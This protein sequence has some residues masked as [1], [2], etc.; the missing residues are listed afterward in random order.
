MSH[1]TSF[2]DRITPDSTLRG[3]EAAAMLAAVVTIF[4]TAAALPNGAT[5]HNPVT[6]WLIAD[7]SWWLVAAGRLGTVAAVFAVLAVL[8]RWR[9]RRYW[10]G[11][12]TLFAGGLW[13]NAT[14]D[15]AVWWA[16]QAGVADLSAGFAV[17]TAVL[18][19]ALVG[20]YELAAVAAGV[21]RGFDRKHVAHHVAVV[22]ITLVVVLGM[23]IAPFALFGMGG[24]ADHDGVAA[25]SSD[26]DVV[27]TAGSD[28]SVRALDISDG[29][30]DW[31]FS[32]SDSVEDVAIAP[33]GETVYS[34]GIDEKLRAIDASDGTEDWNFDGHDGWVVGVAVSPDGETVYTSSE[35]ESVR[36][37]GA[38]DGTEN[39]QS[40]VHSDGVKAVAV[41]PDGDVVYTA[42]SDGTVRGLDASDGTENWQFDDFDSA[43]GVAVS[44]DGE[45]VYA[46]DG[47][48]DDNVVALDASDGTENWRSGFDE[49][50]NAIVASPDG[51]S[52]YVARGDDSVTEFDASDGSEGWTFSDHTDSVESVTV[53]SDGGTVLSGSMDGT[54]WA[55]DASDG[56]QEWQ[57]DGHTASVNG[58]STIAESFG[59]GPQISGSVIESG[60]GD[61]VE[62]AVIEAGDAETTTDADGEYTLTVDEAFE[63]QTI[64]VTASSAIDERTQPTAPPTS[65]V[66]FVLQSG[67]IQVVDQHGNPVEGATVAVTGPTE[68][69]LSAEGVDP[70]EFRQEADALLDEFTSLPDTWDADFDI[71][72]DLV[73]NETR[74]DIGDEY[75]IAHNQDDWQEGGSGLTSSGIEVDEPRLQFDQGDEVLLTVWEMDDTLEDALLPGGNFINRMTGDHTTELFPGT[76]V[77]QS[78]EVE[79]IGPDG[80]V[81]HSWTADPMTFAEIERLAVS[82]IF[83]GGFSNPGLPMVPRP[84]EEDL[85]GVYFG[86]LAPGIYRVTPEGNDLG[87]YTFMYG[88]EDDIT[89]VWLEDVE[90]EAGNLL[91]RAEHIE[92]QLADPDWFHATNVS[93]SQGAVQFGNLPDDVPA[94]DI[95]A[96]KG[97]DAET[98]VNADAEGLWDITDPLEELNI[99]DIRKMDAA[100]LSVGTG[101]YGQERNV[102]SLPATVEG[103]STE[104]APWHEG[105]DE[106]I[107]DRI[108]NATSM[109][110]DDFT[111]YDEALATLLEKR[112]DL[113]E[114]LNERGPF[115]EFLC[116]FRAELCEDGEIRFSD[117]DDLERVSRDLDLLRAAA[118]EWDETRG[119]DAEAEIEDAI[120]DTLTY[121]ADLPDGVADLVNATGA[122]GLLEAGIQDIVDAEV[123]YEDGVTEEVGAEYITIDTEA[124]QLVI[125]E[126]DL[127]DVPVDDVR[128]TFAG[129][130]ESIEDDEIDH[131]DTVIQKTIEIEESFAEVTGDD[132]FGDGRL[133]P[134]YRVLACAD[135]NG[136]AGSACGGTET[137]R[138]PQEVTAREEGGDTFLD[139]EYNADEANIGVPDE[140]LLSGM[141][142]VDESDQEV[143]EA[144]DVEDRMAH[145]VSKTISL[146]GDIDSL[147]DIA[148]RVHYRDAA[149]ETI[150]NAHLELVDSSTVEV[151]SYPTGQRHP[152]Y[153]SVSGEI[154]ATVRDIETTLDDILNEVI[155][156]LGEIESL[157]AIDV[158]VDWDDGT[159]DTITDEY[160]DLEVVNGETEIH[161]SGLD[162]DDR[163]AEA[164]R[165]DIDETSLVENIASQHYLNAIIDFDDGITEFSTPDPDDVSVFFE[166]Q[167]G[168]TESIPPEYWS[169]DG[170]L[171]GVGSIVIEDYPID[172]D[173]AAGELEVIAA[174]GD[175]VY[176]VTERIE[177]PGYEGEPPV[178]RYVATSSLQPDVDQRVHLEVG[179]DDGEDIELVGAEA[180]GPTGQRLG[181]SPFAEDGDPQAMTEVDGSDTGLEISFRTSEGPGIYD[182][183]LLFEDASLAE[184]E[185]A[186]FERSVTVNAIRGGVQHGPV[187]HEMASGDQS[188]AFVAGGLL[189]GDVER[190]DD[191]RT[192]FTVIGERGDVPS[193][194]DIHP[195]SRAPDHVFAIEVVEGVTE[196]RVDRHTTVRLHTSLGEDAL[197]WSDGNPL[198]TSRGEFGQLNKDNGSVRTFTSADGTVEVRTLQSPSFVQRIIFN[199]QRFSPFLISPF[200]AA[201]AGV[202]ALVATT[203]STLAAREVRWR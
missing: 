8:A 92:D 69:F 93:D 14:N 121:V 167:D 48:W 119:G 168:T 13:L 138:T 192:E 113:F 73:G 36:A 20:R 60:T 147:D 186:Q 75:V 79:R 144:T 105:V 166:A 163:V 46:V 59:G 10:L 11:V 52:V 195:D 165:A 67:D 142:A 19:A 123:I 127:R 151:Q 55:I 149:T 135:P 94:V 188:F 83:L 31:S 122:F 81:E 176:S 172:E 131:T 196:E 43:R 162:A 90:D 57:N 85:H 51:D 145:V 181:V 42:S 133:A 96:Y 202:G 86:E 21:V 37:V 26:G 62:G 77:E 30:E 107:L 97:P 78:V 148:V 175:E 104:T 101:F 169:V 17:G 74:I 16:L 201:G 6:A 120:E 27:Y 177:S 158:E 12:G 180:I 68:D 200:G 130:E 153:I 146:A 28:N 24:F 5:E 71:A 194:V 102:E 7:T 29:N 40:D 58:L 2:T 199:V 61:P 183:I 171:T 170:S 161:I 98:L 54:V 99:Q 124:G 110:L 34:V 197:G 82:H 139:I 179:L 178:I 118:G 112:D 140:F 111:D 76:K 15:L 109:A 87:G 136:L 193:S 64:D 100:N 65:G 191:D 156:V 154:D 4:A 164:I 203:L 80:E 3:L 56:T 44:P 190:V 9:S 53:S 45:A 49:S 189:G 25:A 141:T 198:T 184:S 132:R 70:A 88:D 38:S 18:A 125:D 126:F 47:G 39:W 143:D 157:D 84:T 114:R 137:L 106:D 22:G 182:V 103:H 128:L 150:G 174:A 50:G 160:L 95:Y 32:H 41:H 152:Q 187:V 185:R 115:E 35:D 66:S 63:G 91:E 89:N 108:E 173:V 33:G 117:D 116:E 159:T 129:F 1:T 134:G 23:Q 72:E 155:T